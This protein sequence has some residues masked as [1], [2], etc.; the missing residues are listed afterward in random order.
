MASAFGITTAKDIVHDIHEDAT[1]YIANLAISIYA[2]YKGFFLATA[3]ALGLTD[4]MPQIENE[5]I[6]SAIK[7]FINLV[8]SGVFVPI[9]TMYVTFRIKK[10][11][12]SKK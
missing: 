8:S 10:W 7:A 12:K 4:I 6:V 9:T 3:T 11:L 1:E 2:S 5:L